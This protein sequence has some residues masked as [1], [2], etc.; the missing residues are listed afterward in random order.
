MS[1][2]KQ[3]QIEEALRREISRIVLYELS[4]PRIGF[5]TVT[6]VEISRDLRNAKVSV[7]IRGDEK[8]R[9]ESLAA[10]THAR[11]H[12]Q[13]KISKRLPL[14]W[15]PVLSFG[16]DEQAEKDAELTKTIENTRQAD[17]PLD[18]ID[19]ALGGK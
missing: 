8:V 19:E 12:I 2:R 15:T 3:A 6:Q 4:D 17:V 18:E 14:R 13:E 10:L 7:R 1:K 5:L 9:S 11:G 16:L